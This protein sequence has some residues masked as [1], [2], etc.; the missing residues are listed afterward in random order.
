MPYFSKPEHE[1]FTGRRPRAFQ[2]NCCVGTAILGQGRPGRKIFGKGIGP[3]GLIGP[4]GFSYTGCAS[5]IA[6]GSSVGITRSNLNPATPRSCSNSLAVRSLP[7]VITNMFKS[8]NFEKSGSSVSGTTQSTRMSLPFLE[9][10]LRQCL[11]IV[12][13]FSSLFRSGGQFLGGF[14]A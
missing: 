14:R 5:T 10:W 6:V 3:I 4:I 9:I 13:A 12:M 11:R 1:M 2:S 8:M 7:P